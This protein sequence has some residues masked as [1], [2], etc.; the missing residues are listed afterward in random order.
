MPE[1]TVPEPKDPKTQLLTQEDTRTQEKFIPP[2]VDIY[3]TEEGLTVLADLP[4][5]KKE[6]MDLK[7]ADN[8]LTIQGR[9]SHVSKGTPLYKEFELVNFYRQFQVSEE[10]DQAKINAALKHGVLHLKLPRAEKSKPKQVK[11]TIH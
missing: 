11:V 6:D 8:I 3:E 5:V 9:T 4:G 1:K 2:L 7:V 10:I